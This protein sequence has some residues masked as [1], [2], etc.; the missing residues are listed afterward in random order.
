M[1]QQSQ[2]IVPIKYIEAKEYLPSTD[3]E[4][5]VLSPSLPSF[6]PI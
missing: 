3:N 4:P 2:L 6:Q 5:K 1:T